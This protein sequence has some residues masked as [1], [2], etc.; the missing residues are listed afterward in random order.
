MNQTTLPTGAVVVGVDGSARSSQALDWAARQAAHEHHSLVLVHATGGADDLALEGQGLLDEA[1]ARVGSRHPDLAVR[2]HLS[3]ADAR[4]AL[5]ALSSRASLVVLGSRGRGAIR[6]R[7][8]GSVSVAVSGHATCPVM[9]VRPHHPGEVRRGVLVGVD[10]TERTRPTLEF[11]YRQAALHDL[12]VTVMHTFWD[13]LA[14]AIGASLVP[15]SG[16]DHQA[17]RLLLSESVGGMAE[18]FP[19]VKVTLQLARG[20][21][22]DCLIK[23]AQRMHMV[24]VGRHGDSPFARAGGFAGVAR[25][26]VEHAPT[27]VAVVPD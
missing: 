14:P 25:A 16:N 19:E 3:R 20:L 24:V 2:T 17:E 23:A 15:K 7:L 5:V 27:V 1:K 8:L 10:G 11:A 9:V 21:P 6:S 26:V 12:P 22:D 18:K 13:V 4:R